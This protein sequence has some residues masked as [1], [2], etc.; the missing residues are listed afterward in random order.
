MPVTPLLVP[1]DLNGPNLLP[2]ISGPPAEVVLLWSS[3]WG[4][5]WEACAEPFPHVSVPLPSGASAPRLLELQW[6]GTQFAWQEI[7]SWVDW[8]GGHIFGRM[9]KSYLGVLAVAPN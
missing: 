2:E 7:T 4:Q 6:D 3:R 9:T 1:N 8:S 5:G